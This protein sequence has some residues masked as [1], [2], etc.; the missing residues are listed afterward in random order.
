MLNDEDA[1]SNVATQ[2]MIADG[3]FNGEGSLNGY[4]KQRAIW[5]IKS[6]LERRKR[7]S[8]KIWSLN[9]GFNIDEDGELGDYIA[10]DRLSPEAT[11]IQNEQKVLINDLLHSGVLTEKEHKYIEAHYWENLSC[12]EIAR[13]H[14]IS[15]QAVHDC[16]SRGIN[17]LKGIINHGNT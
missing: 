13:M 3:K 9:R 16:I 8:A 11:A 4:R 17:K 7:Q 15:R 10:D 6:Y 1:I 2:I 5:A 14:D 12:A